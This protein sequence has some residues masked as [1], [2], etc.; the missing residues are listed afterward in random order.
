MQQPH[1]TVASMNIDV[2]WK[3]G[4]DSYQKAMKRL[5]SAVTIAKDRPLSDLEE[6]G[7]IQAF[8]FTHELAWNLMKDWFD[9][10]GASNISGSRAKGTY[11]KSS[12]IDL[13]L[14]AP[15]FSLSDLLALENELDDLLL[16][17]EIDLALLHH[18]ENPQL[19]D[20][21]RR[22]GISLKAHCARDA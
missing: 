9:Y 10:Q 17:W 13:V 2:R 14:D 20:H 5:E 18:I 6:L 16:P 15:E 4:L 3:Q 22:V 1:A 11:K 7:L 19:L 8:E 21:I 12:D